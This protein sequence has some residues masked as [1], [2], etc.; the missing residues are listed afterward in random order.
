MNTL[1]SLA[2]CLRIQPLSQKIVDS[3]NFE[4]LV[5]DSPENQIHLDDRILYAQVFHFSHTNWNGL[6]IWHPIFIDRFQ[7]LSEGIKVG[8]VFSLLMKLLDERVTQAC[9]MGKRGDNDVLVT[10]LFNLV[11]KVK[12]NILLA[13]AFHCARLKPS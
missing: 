4:L 3:F 11:V 13:P 12:G 1:A 6:G 9:H 8:E 2:R 5:V 10:N 7:K